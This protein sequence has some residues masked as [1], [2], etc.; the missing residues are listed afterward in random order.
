MV[1]QEEAVRVGA[2]ILAPG[3][4]IYKAELSEEYGFGRYPNVVTSLQF[5]RLL[6]ASGPTMGHV[7]RPSD[8]EHPQ[9]IAFLQCI[10][11]RD[12]SHDYCSA[13]C[14]MYA[15]KEAIM[16]KEHEPGLDVHVFMMDMRAFSKGYWSYFERARDKYG[17]HYTRCR[18]SA[19]REDPHTHDLVI[20]YQDEEGNHFDEHFDMAV[21]SVGMEIAP[22]VK[23]LG[24][25]LGVELD[26]YGFC[27]TVKFNPLETSRAGIYAVGPFREP[28]DI[29]ESVVEASG[30]A[31]SAAAR[32]AESR[33][34]LTTTP[35]Y[36]P[37]RDVSAEEARIG[38]FVCHCGSNIAGY[39]DVPGVAEYAKSLPGVVHAENN[40]YTCSQD[41]IK[42]ITEQVKELGLNR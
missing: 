36:P 12:Q 1:A 37:E 21:L 2:V 32:L 41:S 38:V 11:S 6:S 22:S 24:R 7:Q 40:L 19:L 39:L 27:H 13:V 28:K 35:E 26:E 31:A 10:G 8:G 9:K 16:A 18:I 14:C 33:F 15:T 17:I 25:R 23:E 30:A 20:H 4:Q 42:H 29:P 3:Y 34:T 5:E